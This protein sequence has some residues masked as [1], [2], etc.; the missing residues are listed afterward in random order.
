MVPRRLAKQ[1]PQT[2]ER[3]EQVSQLEAVFLDLE[4]WI[5]LINPTVVQHGAVHRS[6]LNDPSMLHNPDDVVAKVLSAVVQLQV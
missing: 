5:S 2:L 3:S 1:M 6:L 4:I